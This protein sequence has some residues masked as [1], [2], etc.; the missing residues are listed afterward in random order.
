R[1]ADAL[2]AAQAATASPESAIH[3][4]AQLL[5]GES[6][7][8]LKRY[9]EAQAAYEAVLQAPTS[10]LTPDALYGLGWVHLRQQQPEAA[11][12]AFRRLLDDFPTHSLLSSA[13]YYLAHTLADLDRAPEVRALLATYDSAYPQ[14]PLL[15]DALY[16][17]GWSELTT[18]QPQ[19]AAQSFE[20]FLALAP[21]HALAPQAR[22][23]LA[24]ALLRQGKQ[25]EG[26]QA[27]DTLLGASATTAERLWNISLLAQRFTAPTQAQ[28]AWQR[29]TREF[30]ASPLAA[31]A[32]LELARVAF[33]EQRYA[34]ALAAAQAATAS[35]ESEVRLEAQLLIGES[36]LRREQYTAALE[37]FQRALDETPTDHPFRYR[38]LAGLGLTHEHLRQW[39]EAIE[40]YRLVATGTDEALKEWAA[41]RLNA[42]KDRSSPAPR[43]TRPGNDEPRKE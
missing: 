39:T 32:S 37:A 28:Q 42:L 6:Q 23:Q 15:A 31:Q 1:Y 5:I 14:S 33:A 29:L 26:L 21:A 43:K 22:L 24:D 25:P 3:L 35:P 34:D 36:Q 19:A 7:L 17:R 11:A 9:P 13:T 4:D 12:R 8:Q 2:A 40:S 30:P 27:L 18:D 10:P 41:E 20:R 38:T 16:L